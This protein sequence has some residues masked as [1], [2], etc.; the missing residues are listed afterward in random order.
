[1]GNACRML[2]SKLWGLA[3]YDI[4]III[5]K[6]KYICLKYVCLWFLI[7]HS[8]DFGMVFEL[9]GIGTKKYRLTAYLTDKE[10]SVCKVEYNP[11]SLV[12]CILY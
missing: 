11:C 8:D 6:N 3:L 4:I 5:D 7:K 9:L 1:M 12:A 2:L 10:L